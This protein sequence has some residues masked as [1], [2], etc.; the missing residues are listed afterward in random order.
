MFSFSMPYM[1]APRTTADQLSKFVV[2]LGTG[3]F[4]Q[5]YDV[6]GRLDLISLISS[7]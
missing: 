6:S 1:A 3:N 4:E 2:S 7:D 5:A